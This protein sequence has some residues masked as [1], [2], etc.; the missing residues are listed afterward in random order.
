MRTSGSPAR[1]GGVIGAV[2]GIAGAAVY[3]LPATLDG[4]QERSGSPVAVTDRIAAPAAD[5]DVIAATITKRLGSHTAGM[6]VDRASGRVV[7]AVTNSTDAQTVSAAGAIP[8]KVAH[9]GA[10]LTNATA[11][12]RR[13]VTIPGTGWAV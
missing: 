13:S 3:V 2:I 11:A 10:E 7:A 4:A 1:Q 5:P 12:L 8:K 9:S 6:W